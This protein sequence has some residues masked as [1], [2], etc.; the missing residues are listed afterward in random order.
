MDK[1]KKNIKKDV[2][3]NVEKKSKKEA[4]KKVSE[5]KP[6]K[7]VSEPKPKKEPK[8]KITEDKPKK[9]PKKEVKKEPK[10]ELKKE[11]KKEPKKETKNKKELKINDNDNDNY[12]IYSNTNSKS[13]FESKKESKED[14]LMKSLLI[15]F[16]NK[17]YLNN[18]I[19]IIS[20]KSIIS[21]RILD[22]FVTNY[23]KKKNIC[24]QVKTSNGKIKNFIVY[25]DY[26]NQLDGYSKKQFDPFCR[27]ERISFVDYD[28]N[29][30]STT[31][32]QLNFFRWTIENNIL[33]YIFENYKEIE[34]DMNIS[35]KNLYKK[36]DNTNNTNNITN[37]NNNNTV[38]NRRKR[39]ELSVCATKTINKHNIN[40]TVEFD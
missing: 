19:S 34:N 32:G 30:Y 28:N 20:G 33:N 11:L 35:L 36:K 17:E 3:K 12:S 2:E 6:L 26:K 8:K 7:K 37:L 38:K 18:F 16:K 22:W 24:Y 39:K 31:I 15:F 9:E 14:L 27:R 10:K 23:S 4:L 5:P 1:D 25:L 29:V 40:I 21:L 13:N